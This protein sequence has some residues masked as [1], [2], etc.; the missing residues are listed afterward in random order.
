MTEA[1]NNIRRFDVT[2]APYRREVVRNVMEL[3]KP[4]PYTTIS[5]LQACAEMIIAVLIA[6]VEQAMTDDDLSDVE[7]AMNLA[8]TLG[9]LEGAANLVEGLPFIGIP[10]TEEMED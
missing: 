8:K 9:Q 1:I 2:P 10:A 7:I 5:D 6:S 3:L 4:G